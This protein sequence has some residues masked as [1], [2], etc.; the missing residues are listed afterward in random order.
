VVRITSWAYQ[1]LKKW[2]PHKPFG[3]KLEKIYKWTAHSMTSLWS[4]KLCWLA[5]TLKL[6]E[7]CVNNNW[8]SKHLASITYT[9]MAFMGS[10][11]TCGSL[12]QN[13]Q[14]RSKWFQTSLIQKF[15]FLVIRVINKHLQKSFQIIQVLRSF[16][17]EL[18]CYK[19]VQLD[20][21]YT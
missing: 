6:W 1:L 13:G 8:L 21:Y 17:P 12:K 9:C 19:L 20:I 3:I 18:H 11:N 10:R 16:V 2:I 15:F 5:S 7:K 14:L 4:L